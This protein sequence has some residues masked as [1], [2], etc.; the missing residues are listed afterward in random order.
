MPELW[1]RVAV[2]SPHIGNAWCLAY[3]YA[4]QAPIAPAVMPELGTRVHAKPQKW[5][6]GKT[7]EGSSVHAKATH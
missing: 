7:R 2:P 5:R 3:M 1:D 4:A 6:R